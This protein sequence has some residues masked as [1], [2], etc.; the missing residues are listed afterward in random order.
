MIKNKDIL[1]IKRNGETEELN[2]EKIKQQIAWAIEGLDVNPLELE[3]LINTQLTEGVKTTDIQGNLILSAASLCS[4]S[5]SDWRYVAGKLF[6]SNY[7]KQLH[8]DKKD[9]NKFGYSN[10]QFWVD[11]IEKGQLVDL[12]KSFSE[13][14]MANLYNYM[15]PERDMDYD[16]AG[17][18]MLTKRYLLPLEAL[19]EAYMYSAMFL[20]QNESTRK[21]KKVKELYDA[22]SLRQISLATPMLSNSRTPKGSLTSCFITG[23]ADSIDSIFNDGVTALAKIS[24]N[25][26]GAGVNISQIRAKGSEVRGNPNASGGVVPWIK[27]LNDTAIAVDQNGKRA[28]AATISLDVWHLDI[29]EFLELQTEAGDQRRKAHD[30]FPQ[31]VVQDEFMYRVHTNQEWTMVCPYEVERYYGASLH[32]CWGEHFSSFYK[33]IESDVNYP[34]VRKKINAKDL[35]KK[36]MRVQVETGLPYLFFK[37]TANAYNPNK[38]DGY[39]PAGNLCMESYSNVKAGEDTHCCNLI[40]LNFDTIDMDNMEELM[41]ITQ[42]AI[43][44]LDNSID[45]TTPPIAT[46]KQHNDKY[47]TVGLGAMG[48]ADYLAK[49]KLMYGEDSSKQVTKIFEIISFAAIDASCRLAAERGAYPK[50]DNSEW[51]QGRLLGG[52]SVEEIYERSVTDLDW[53]YLAEQVII[54]GIRNSQ[55][56]AIAPNTSSSLIQGCSA[57]IL[58]VYSKFFYDSWGKGNVPIMPPAIKEYA[59]FYQENKFLDQTKVIDTVSDIQFWVDTGI[60]MELL[61]NL[62]D[63]AYYIG[64]KTTAANIYQTLMYAWQKGC[65]AVYYVR[66]VQKDETRKGTD[67]CDAC[68]N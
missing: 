21:L 58:P 35:F 63:N 56:M 2:V 62:N 55:L 54:H 13:A 52:R 1:V 25:G 28:G 42:L 32:H 66:T 31:I 36:I 61:F 22:L 44:T 27:I 40:S 24:Q 53:G 14:Q 9:S 29:P 64:S 48:L 16:F 59:N 51:S 7:R 20:M 10:E 67:G 68:A 4:L 45:L 60:S 6:M 17:V 23:I 43:R 34:G 15:K 11:Q 46:A 38:H 49:S 18:S 65:K 47:R 30:I 8:L 39:I 5:G 3:M 41:K 37:D 50:F 12:R 26:G 33:I 19:Q 57:S